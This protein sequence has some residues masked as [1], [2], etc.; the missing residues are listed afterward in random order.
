MSSNELVIQLKITEYIILF[1]SGYIELLKLD[2]QNLEIEIKSN[3]LI[4]SSK[5]IIKNRKEK[6]CL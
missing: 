4:F 2:N 5:E 1:T 3:K 6:E